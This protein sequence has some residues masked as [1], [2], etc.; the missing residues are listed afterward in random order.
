MIKKIY[1]DQLQPGMF[2]TKLN[3]PLWQRLFL[4]NNKY[5]KDEKTIEQILKSR[6]Y[7]VY[8]DTTKGLDV[9]KCDVEIKK[10]L[11]ASFKEE[12]IEEVIEEPIEK[13]PESVTYKDEIKRAKAL[14]EELNL[15][16]HEVLEDAKAGKVPEI[17]KVDSA[18]AN[19]LDSVTRNK[20]A[21]MSLLLFKEK[22]QY[23]YHHSISVS[24]LTIAFCKHI[25]LD[26]S[27]VKDIGAGAFLHDIGKTKI[28]L[29]ILN[30]AGPLNKKESAI[31]AKH[32]IYSKEILSKIEGIS[33]ASIEAAAHHHERYDGNGYPNG[34]KKDEISLAGQMTGIADCYDAMTSN[35]VYKKR[36]E[37][38]QALRY[39]FRL[40][41]KEFK[42]ELMHYFIQCVGI[43]PV[44][45]LVRLKNG[46]L[47][48]VL[49]TADL[50]FSKPVI[51]VVYDA[52]R[53]LNIITKVIDLAQDYGGKG[54]NEIEGI[55]PIE[56]WNINPLNY[57]DI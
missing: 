33:P 5:I 2:I 40:A 32:V 23:T 50:N 55:E 7:E 37:P 52:K 45:S 36:L 51:R 31:M 39:L 49:E 12:V 38:A 41:G 6:I 1:V 22:D 11:M 19:I 30:K 8:I 47:G 28:P 34:L 17:K 18:V 15:L 3:C 57:L 21:L 27:Q 25:G 54:G 20:N 56:K 9:Y 53:N 14:K 10:E 26:S 43:Y 48:V 46:L 44:G 24:V 4:P 42:E 13:P 29:K 35:R 16:V